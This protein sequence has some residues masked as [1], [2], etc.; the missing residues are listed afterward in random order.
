MLHALRKITVYLALETSCT[1]LGVHAC[2]AWDQSLI[3]VY[4]STGWAVK[5]RVTS[6][7]V[8]HNKHGRNG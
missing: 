1:K 4:D 7:D 8:L 2:H 5:K 3:Q 6:L